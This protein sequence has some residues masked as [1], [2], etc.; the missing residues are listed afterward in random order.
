V[1]LPAAHGQTGS[2]A[3]FYA[4]SEAQPETCTS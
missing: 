2:F 1:H 3:W 4:Q